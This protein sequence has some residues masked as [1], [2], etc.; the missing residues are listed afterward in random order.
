MLRRERTRNYDPR[1]S[2]AT[3]PRQ[4]GFR[5][6]LGRVFMIAHIK[7]RTFLDYI[8]SFHVLYGPRQH[9]DA[10][11]IIWIEPTRPIDQI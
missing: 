8:H 4:G 3:A 1:N 11:Q 6:R 7:F 9:F 10:P 2:F 5:V